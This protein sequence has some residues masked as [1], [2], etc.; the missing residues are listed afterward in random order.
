MNEKIEQ[1][2]AKFND[3]V[4]SANYFQ[5][6][7]DATISAQLADLYKMKKGAKSYDNDRLISVHNFTVPHLKTGEIFYVGSTTHTIDTKINDL[8]MQ[9]NRQN[10]WLLAEIY[11]SFET[12]IFELY[13][14]SGYAGVPIWKKDDLPQG[15]KN[16][17]DYFRQIENKRT[18]TSKYIM[19]QLAINIPEIK[20]VEMKNTF[21]DINIRFAIRLIANFRH[22]IVHKHGIIDDKE[23]LISKVIKES[24][25]SISKDKRSFYVS[26]VDYYLGNGGYSNHILLLKRK[27]DLG[28]PIET[29]KSRINDM[30]SILLSYAH[31]VCE[32]IIKYKA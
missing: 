9:H 23:A 24:G 31:F 20:K 5:S 27:V 25:M 32:C 8:W 19:G 17:D 26:F 15:E 28:L 12:F 6:V 2:L 30:F 16:L 4:V 10:Q 21:R 14:I 3:R 11:E 18:I 13:A 29:H 1:A 22:L 7:I